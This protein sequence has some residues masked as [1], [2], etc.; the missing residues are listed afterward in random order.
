MRGLEPISL[1][2]GANTNKMTGEVV[3]LKTAQNMTHVLVRKKNCSDVKWIQSGFGS[4]RVS[5]QH[6]LDTNKGQSHLI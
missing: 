1:Q 5:V 6:D 2:F 4:R 3:I